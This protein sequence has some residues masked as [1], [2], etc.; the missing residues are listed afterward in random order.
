MLDKKAVKAKVI[1]RVA[2]S[3]L[4]KGKSPEQVQD[5]I[6]TMLDMRRQ[7]VG[8]VLNTH[9]LYSPRGL[10]DKD[11]IKTLFKHSWDPLNGLHKTVYDN[12]GMLQ[13]SNRPVM[14]RATF[15][16]AVN[17]AG[18]KNPL[19]LLQY[20]VGSKNYSKR[21]QLASAYALKDIKRLERLY[22]RLD[23]Q[24]YRRPL[25]SLFSVLNSA[26]PESFFKRLQKKFPRISSIVRKTRQQYIPDQHDIR[27]RLQALR[28]TREVVNPL[29]SSPVLSSLPNTGDT[30]YKG[31]LFGNFKDYYKDG[32]PIFASPHFEVASD[33]AR[34]DEKSLRVIVA[35]NRAKLRRQGKMPITTPYL[36]T[37]D[38]SARLRYVQAQKDKLWRPGQDLRDLPD[39]ELVFD[40]SSGPFQ[41]IVKNVYMPIKGGY[42]VAGPART[43][44][45]VDAYKKYFPNI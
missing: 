19:G 12:R 39:Y 36:A 30:V 7:P 10:K 1:R 6:A 15:D 18:L 5:F 14:S 9:R 44:R 8:K 31:T 28:D 26:A 13:M 11:R 25:N 41:E 2:D 42:K 38:Q 35:L 16:M 27:R 4:A 32:D 34:P 45:D 29:K 22:K 37:T 3:M 24:L 23:R 43:I 21:L 33:Y 17:K 40:N 20:R